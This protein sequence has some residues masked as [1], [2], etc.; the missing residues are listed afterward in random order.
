MTKEQP[1]FTTDLV[2]LYNRSIFKTFLYIYIF[3][4]EKCRLM[5]NRSLS[6]GNSRMKNRKMW[7]RSRRFSAS[8]NV[9][10][11]SFSIFSL[12]LSREIANETNR[13]KTKKLRVLEAVEKLRKNKHFS[14]QKNDGILHV[15]T[16]RLR[17]LWYC[18]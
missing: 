8:K 7:N 5:R 1:M 9:I 6:M 16:I 13:L 4:D 2:N 14:S 10:S 18:C 17:I 12:E 3:Q 11:L 15:F